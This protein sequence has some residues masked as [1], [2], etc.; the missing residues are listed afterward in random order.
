MYLNQNTSFFKSN[1]N[2]GTYSKE[3]GYLTIDGRY[4]VNIDKNSMT[5]KDASNNFKTVAFL[6]WRGP[7]GIG[8]LTNDKNKAIRKFIIKSLIESN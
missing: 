1:L 3:D 8:I 6:E 5:I 4:E 2:T 7:S